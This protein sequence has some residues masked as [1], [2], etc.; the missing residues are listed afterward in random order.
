MEYNSRKMAFSATVCEYCLLGFAAFGLYAAV[1]GDYSTPE[2]P[3]FD[4]SDVGAFNE[5]YSQ[6]V[7]SLPEADGRQLKSL[8]EGELRRERHELAQIYLGT[9]SAIDLVT[10][11][12]VVNYPELGY[13]PRLVAH[14]IGLDKQDGSQALLIL[15][16]RQLVL[17]KRAIYRH[18]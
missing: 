15:K 16:K 6:V 10:N 8:V 2:D 14:R 7:E 5:S 11:P 17:A 3:C 4:C 12:P 13:S 9:F 1:F 18:L